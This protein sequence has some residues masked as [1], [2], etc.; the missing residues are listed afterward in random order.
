MVVTCNGQQQQ[1]IVVASGDWHRLELGN[2]LLKAGENKVRLDVTPVPIKTRKRTTYFSLSA[3]EL[4]QPDVK[5]AIVEKAAAARQQPDWFKDAGYG[6]MFQWT[7]RATP[8]QGPI[9]PWEEKISDFDLDQFIQLVDDSGASYVIWSITWGQQ[10]ISAPV[11]SLDEIITGR[12]TRRDLLGKMADRLHEKGVELIF[13]YHY[14]YECYHSQDKAWLEAAGGFKADKTQLFTNVMQIVSEAGDR[15]GDRLDGWWFDGG[16]RYLNCHFDESSGAEGILTTPFKEFT[17]AARTGNAKRIVGYNSWKKPR[18]TEYQDYYGGEGKKSFRAAER[19]VG[20][21]KGGR[22][23]GLQAHGCFILEKRWRH[24]DLNTPIKDP[25]CNLKQ[26]TE[27]VTQAK[28]GRYPLSI[29]LEMYE[30]GSV[31]S[32]SAAL[33]KALKAAVEKE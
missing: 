14:G 9:K 6:L 26:M 20:V 1:A 3:L 5:T 30:D 24:I 7:N 25:K 22:Q 8:P 32:K 33:L 11:K 27:F 31:S 13:Y 12:T 29:N 19:T 18:I 2:I 10:Y 15:Y 4:A 16:A 28:K 21:F 17:A 23:Q